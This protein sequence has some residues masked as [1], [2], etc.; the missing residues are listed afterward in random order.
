MKFL[1]IPMLFHI[2]ELN[3]SKR[4]SHN[5]EGKGLSVSLTPL[6]WKK[7]AKG[8]VSG[9]AFELTKDNARFALYHESLDE[10]IVKWANKNNLIT[11]I[12]SL[13][14][15]SYNDEMEQDIY[16]KYDSV[17]DIQDE[18]QE[19]FSDLDI[20]NINEYLPT[21]NLKNLLAPVDVTGSIFCMLFGLYVAA[22]FPHCDGVWFD[23]KISVSQ[24]KA[25]SG[26]I[27]DHKY[28]NWNTN[29]IEDAQLPEE[30]D[31]EYLDY[32]YV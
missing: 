2:G 5:F 12:K 9:D 20:K 25:P 14:V 23:E 26:L 16:E 7:I 29:K 31:V 4:R 13:F 3:I 19:D 30:S 21:E 22:K 28:K 32:E 1:K 15:V 10:E 6:E 8:Y 18:Y 17:S 27:F 11:T 24:Y